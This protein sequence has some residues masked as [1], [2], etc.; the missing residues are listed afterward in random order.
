MCL[1]LQVP[2]HILKAVMRH[3]VFLIGAAIFS[4]AGGLR[5]GDGPG[6]HKEAAIP[7]QSA[8]CSQPAKVRVEERAHISAVYSITRPVRQLQ[9]KHAVETTRQQ[10]ADMKTHQAN[11][12]KIREIKRGKADVLKDA[13]GGKGVITPDGEHSD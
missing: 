5:A 12:D 13:D 4:M 9:D 11:Q 7:G 3:I 2:F 8:D 6:L 10:C 1:P